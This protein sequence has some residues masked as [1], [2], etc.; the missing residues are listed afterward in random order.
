MDFEAAI[1][2]KTAEGSGSAGHCRADNLPTEGR[3]TC[4]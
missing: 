1:L 2:A 3:F 4:L